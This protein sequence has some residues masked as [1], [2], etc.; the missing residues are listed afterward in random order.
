MHG[1]TLRN[2]LGARYIIGLALPARPFVNDM[3]GWTND[4]PEHPPSETIAARFLPQRVVTNENDT[5]LLLLL[6]GIKSHPRV[7]E[8]STGYTAA[9]CTVYIR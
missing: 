2:S 5:L 6:L 8:P 1:Y 7:T 9:A 4:M 3:D